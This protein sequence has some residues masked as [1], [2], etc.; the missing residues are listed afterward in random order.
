[1][2]ELDQKEF[3]DIFGF[4]EIDFELSSD[5]LAMEVSTKASIHKWKLK[6]LLG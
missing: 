6:Q 2:K 3:D 1:M 4:D 5:D